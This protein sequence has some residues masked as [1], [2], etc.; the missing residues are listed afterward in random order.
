MPR[1]FNRLFDGIQKKIS[2]VGGMR[3][4]L[5]DWGIASKLN[6]ISNSGEPTHSLYDRLIFNKFKDALGGRC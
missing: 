1:V 6:K 3:R 5:L 2:E 4:R